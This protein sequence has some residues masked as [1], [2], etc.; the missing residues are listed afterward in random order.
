MKTNKRL[1]CTA[2]ALVMAFGCTGTVPG[3]VFEDMAITASAE[4]VTSEDGR[5][6]YDLVF[7]EAHI[8]KYLET[9]P[10]VVIPSEI[11]GHEVAEVKSIGRYEQ[12]KTI[13]S[14][15]FPDTIKTIGSF[16]MLVGL[17]KVTLGK[18][19]T[20][21]GGSA[22]S[23]CYAL[24]EINF[25]NGLKTIGGGAFS[26]TGLENIT[27]PDTLTEIGGNAF[28]YTKISSITIPDSVTSLGWHTFACCPNLETVVL[29]DNLTTVDFPTVFAGCEKIKS[30]NIPKSCTEFYGPDNSQIGETLE[31]AGLETLGGFESNQNLKKVK[32]DCKTI[33]GFN[34]CEHLESVEFG[35]NVREISG[36][37]NCT[38]LMS[39]TIP[40]NVTKIDASFGAYG[41]TYAQQHY[42]G[43]TIYCYKGTAGAEYAEKCAEKYGYKVV[44]LEDTVKGD[45]NG[46]NTVDV[47]DLVLVQ[48]AVAGWKIDENSKNAADVT[49]DGVVDVDD[50]IYI[51]KKV[52]GWKV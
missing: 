52:A 21:I 37:F 44:Y 12:D 20:V 8:T 29:S 1:I 17:E 39:V 47:D 7:G 26:R 51:Q 18:N 9:D 41:E 13:K 31:I 43:F 11:D 34:G 28:A 42:K 35:S 40:K 45:V 46:D 48:K 27:L 30:F 38:S 5:F 10:D 25:P 19:V 15:V 6:Q 4:T 3:G 50:I 32:L 49:G 22:F 36:F 23:D 24:K 2:A 33:S 14:I 16:Q